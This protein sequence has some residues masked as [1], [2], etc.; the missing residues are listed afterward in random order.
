MMPG[1]VAYASTGHA[2]AWKGSTRGFMTYFAFAVVEAAKRFAAI[3]ITEPG[4]L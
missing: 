4:H 2:G 1:H 3:G